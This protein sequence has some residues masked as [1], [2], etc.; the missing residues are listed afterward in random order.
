MAACFG[1]GGGG[2]LSLRDSL[3]TLWL[4]WRGSAA[5]CGA[6]GSCSAGA[7]DARLRLLRTDWAPPPPLEAGSLLG[8]GLPAD[9]EP[10]QRAG[11]GLRVSIRV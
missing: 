2:R 6:S 7:G 3:G 9:R 5:S 10:R 11:Y 1:G 8:L 4:R